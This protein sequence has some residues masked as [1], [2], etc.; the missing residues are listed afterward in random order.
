VV[1]TI[2]DMATKKKV[3]LSFRDRVKKEASQ[4][5]KEF[6]KKTFNLL[7]SGFGLVAAL[8]WNELI[9]DLITTYI[10][11]YFGQQSGL[12]SRAIYAVMITFL[13]VLITY[14]FSKFADKK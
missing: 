4:F 11:P 12:I 10:Q 8:A 3:K 14:N 7:T 5:K 2:K 1:Y 13:A 9:K 6:A